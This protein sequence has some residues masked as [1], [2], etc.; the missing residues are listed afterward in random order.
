MC[1]K[2]HVLVLKHDIKG[3]YFWSSV[4]CN[5][6]TPFCGAELDFLSYVHVY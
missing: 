4:N 2:A 3:S 6:L 1:R 5:I